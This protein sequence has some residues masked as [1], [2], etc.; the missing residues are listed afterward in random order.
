MHNIKLYFNITASP[1]IIEY[2]VP[3]K[4]WGNISV[5]F[6]IAFEKVSYAHQDCIYL[7][8]NTVKLVIL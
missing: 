7:T 8:K 3:L 1:Q 4:I 5:Q 6:F 2:R